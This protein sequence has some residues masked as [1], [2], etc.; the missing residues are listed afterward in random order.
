MGRR[1][2]KRNSEKRL[3][4]PKVTTFVVFNAK[5]SL[6]ESYW[7][8]ENGRTVIINSERYIAI[9]D[10]FHGDLRQKITK[11]EL[12]LAWFM[13]DGARPHRATDH[14][15]ISGDSSGVVLSAS[16]QIM[17]PQSHDLNPLAVWFWGAAKRKF[18]TNKP[19]TPADLKR[20]VA[21]MQLKLPLKHG[22]VDQNFC[23]RMKAC[24]NKNRLI[25]SRWT[26]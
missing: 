9:P 25:S 26:T 3:K 14:W 15:T 2:A 4:G 7:F 19:Q 11:V 6:L 24:F 12:R 22:R 21:V 10:H 8:E 17:G 5:H 20:K 16:T 23:V 1:E 13:Q 18:C